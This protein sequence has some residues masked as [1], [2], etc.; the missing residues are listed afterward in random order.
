MQVSHRQR[1]SGRLLPGVAL[2]VVGMLG[3]PEL[4]AQT[5]PGFYGGAGV[6][7]ANFSVEE[8]DNGCC[9][10]YG[11]PDYVDGDE[12]TSTELNFGYRVNRYLG[13]EF[14]FFDSTLEW[15]QNLVYVPVLNDVYNNFVDVD[16]RTTQFSAVGILPFAQVW[17]AYLRGGFAY[18]QGDSSQTLVRASDSSLTR[19]SFD[20]SGTSFLFALG[21]GVSP[22]PAWHLRF[23]FQ[24]FGVDRDLI[25]ATGS[26]TVDSMAFSFQFRPA[27]RRT[28]LADVPVKKK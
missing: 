14:G 4:E 17:E 6:G 11:F 16:L 5:P 21:V 22:R 28:P 2:A 15:Q 18:W 7:L 25:G 27:G 3:S 20:E 24:L 9:Y 26:T 23:E 1:Y 10:Y 13:A 8:D 12:S 19:R